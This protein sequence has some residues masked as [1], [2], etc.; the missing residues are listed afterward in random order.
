MVTEE[1]TSP[2]PAHGCR[3]CGGPEV[4]GGGYDHVDD[5]CPEYRPPGQ[6]AGL[7]GTADT[8]PPKT[9]E[10]RAGPRFAQTFYVG[11]PHTPWID[12]RVATMARLREHLARTSPAAQFGTSVLDYREY[13]EREPN[14]AWSVKLWTDAARSGATHLLQLQDDAVVAPNFWPALE[15]LVA[16]Y[17]D[18][19]ICL[20]TPHPAGRTLA[21]R[22]VH[23]YTLA[24][25]LIGVG[26]VVPCD[27]LRGERIRWPVG[28]L[29]W[30]AQRLKAGA[31]EAVTEDTLIAMF[32]VA[33][34]RRIVCPCPTII[35]HDTTIASS[36]GNDEHPFRRP[37]VTWRDGDVCGFTAA[38]LEEPAFWSPDDGIP[39]LG[40]FYGAVGQMAAVWS[41]DYTPEQ[42]KAY[43]ADVCPR[44]HSRFFR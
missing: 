30:R 22:G 7:I 31:V 27:S 26:Y 14:H 21:R 16:A 24:D 4:A 35:D 42:A 9:G 15:A 13:T 11:V 33:T 18:E 39:H 34:G 36:Y 5:G 25:G 19:L 23:T 12:A 6:A 10:R 8:E 41:K 1:A 17:P 38:Q 20:E 44:E 40:R 43:E 32:A 2:S 3:G 29:E 28:L 37:A